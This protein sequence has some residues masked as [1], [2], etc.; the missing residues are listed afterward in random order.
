LPGLL[1]VASGMGSRYVPGGRTFSWGKRTEAILKKW[2]PIFKASVVD[3]PNYWH[4]EGR[5]A[6]LRWKGDNEGSSLYPLHPTGLT[7]RYRRQST[8][9][10]G[11][12]EQ[13]YG[14]LFWELR[15]PLPIV[16]PY[17]VLIALVGVDWTWCWGSLMDCLTW[18]LIGHGH[19]SMPKEP[20]VA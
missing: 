16:A 7:W 8:L 3:W 1:N 18:A 4:F 12:G 5:S 2:E 14:L 9:G 15:R 17:L 20:E 19:K 10:S 11:Q 13:V 6:V